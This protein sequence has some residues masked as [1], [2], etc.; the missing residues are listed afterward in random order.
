M[1][2]K[3]KEMMIKF[4]GHQIFENFIFEVEETNQAADLTLTTARDQSLRD[5]GTE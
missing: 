3:Y 4:F 5:S 1:D 2:R